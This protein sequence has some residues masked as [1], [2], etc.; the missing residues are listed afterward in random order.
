MNKR[1]RIIAKHNDAFVNV[2]SEEIWQQFC[3][4]GAVI[5]QECAGVV[6]WDNL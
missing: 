6:A 5:C 4:A 1:M 2:Q 3:C